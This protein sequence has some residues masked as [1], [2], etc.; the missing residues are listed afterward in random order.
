[1]KMRSSFSF[2]LVAAALA[3]AQSPSGGHGRFGPGPR[4]LGAEAGVP[5][6]VVTGAPFREIWSRK[7]PTL[8]PTAIA[9]IKS[10]LRTWF[11]TAKAAHAARNRWQAWVRWPP[12]EAHSR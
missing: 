12:A 11:A 4:F 9:S 7:A 8:W 2:L 5:R 10:A 1:M 6:R 3:W